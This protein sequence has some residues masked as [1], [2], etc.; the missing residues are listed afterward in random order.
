MA[1]PLLCPTIMPD[2]LDPLAVCLPAINEV[3]RST[4]QRAYHD[5]LRIVGLLKAAADIQAD[6]SMVK[7]PSTWEELK[8]AVATLKAVISKRR[9]QLKAMRP[10]AKGSGHENYAEFMGLVD[11]AE[12]C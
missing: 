2:N 4:Y 1:C 11:S 3:G 5:R 12:E 9:A 7:A 8:P 10:V 6:L